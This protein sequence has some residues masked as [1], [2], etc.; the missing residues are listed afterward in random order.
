LYEM[1]SGRRAFEGENALEIISSIL[2]DEPKAIRQLLPA[3]PQE[4]ERIVN[5]TLRK[6]ADE[7]YQ[8]ARGLLTD[9]K[10]VRGDLEF[11]DKL[12]RSSAP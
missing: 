2:K 1:L 10:D 9:L 11:Q 5:K 12:E 8:T 7:R 3:V 6:D 4:I